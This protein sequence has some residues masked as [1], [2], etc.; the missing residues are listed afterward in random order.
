MSE[1][2]TVPIVYP[3]TQLP[4]F[5]EQALS[6]EVRDSVPSVT[7]TVLAEEFMDSNTAKV[8]VDGCVAAD[9][10][11]IH[12]GITDSVYVAKEGREQCFD[13]CTFPS[14]FTGTKAE[15]G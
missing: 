4:P 14:V 13:H 6:K 15:V 10:T 3:H 9:G 1:T 11:L 12:W 5:L 8:T 2:H 7:E